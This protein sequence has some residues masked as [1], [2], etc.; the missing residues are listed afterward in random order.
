MGKGKRGERNKG[1]I[2]KVG[3]K[4]GGRKLGDGRYG[5]GKGIIC[6]NHKKSVDDFSNTTKMKEKWYVATTDNDR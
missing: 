5:E 3:Q 1:K 4:R 6:K 2:G